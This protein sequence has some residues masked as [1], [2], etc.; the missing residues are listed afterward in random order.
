MVNALLCTGKYA[1]KPYR[2]ENIC[3]NIYCVEELC[4]LLSSNPFMIDA[5]IMD[6]KL[7][8]WIDTECGLK[9]LA[10]QLLNLLHKGIQPGIYADAI[11]DYVNYNT[12]AERERIREALQG[13]AGLS[14]ME[15]AKKQ[16]DYLIKKRKYQLAI[17]EYDRILMELP[18]AEVEL[19]AAVYHNMGV[20]Y[21]Y[22]FRFESAARYYKRAFEIAGREESGIQYLLAQKNRMSEG[23][24]ITFLAENPKYYELSLKVEGLWQTAKEQFEA[25]RENRM[26][27]ALKIYKE[28]GN[29]ASY[30][31]EID[32]IISGLKEDYRDCVTG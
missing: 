8:E 10:H 26:L 23:E 4:Y 1:T 19:R 15:R 6:R 28:E 16:G 12:K 18:E 32:R 21:G 5:G 20:A 13:S 31:E 22:L 2:F 25:T 27:S 30:Y 14:D 11:L 17:A 9:E 29:A 7:A 24:Y 3:V